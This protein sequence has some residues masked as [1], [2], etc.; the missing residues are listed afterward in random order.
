MISVFLD[1][2]SRG[3]KILP[4]DGITPVEFI[5]RNVQIQNW[6]VNEPPI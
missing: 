4:I 5:A 1:K 3:N 2:H 6:H